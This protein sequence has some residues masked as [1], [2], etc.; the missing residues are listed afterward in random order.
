MKLPQMRVVKQTLQLSR[1][2]NRSCGTFKWSSAHFEFSQSR[3]L[4][5]NRRTASVQEGLAEGLHR[6]S[7]QLSGF[8]GESDPLVIVEQDALVLF[9]LLLFTYGVF[10]LTRIRL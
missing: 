8:R 6:S 9:L 3:C 4:C 2:D 5:G 1:Y 7:G 10:L